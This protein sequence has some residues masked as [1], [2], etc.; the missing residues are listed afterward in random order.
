[1]TIDYQAK[2]M[3]LAPSGFHVDDSD[4]DPNMIGRK[5][6][7]GSRTPKVL[8]RRRSGDSSPKKQ[9]MTTRMARW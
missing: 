5:M 6:L 1:M 8:A 2:T 9:R 4:T 7:E 3:L